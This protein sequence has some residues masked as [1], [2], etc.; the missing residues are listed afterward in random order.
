ME[1][2]NKE[3]TQILTDYDLNKGY[4]KSDYL[5]IEVPE[6]Q[7]VEEQSHYE[8][9]AEYENG[10]KDLK[11]V[12][13]VKGITYQPAHTEKQEIKV[14]IPYTE[15]ELAEQ[16]IVELKT[17]LQATD[18]Q[19]IKFA[20]GL[21]SSIDYEPIKAQRQAWRNKINELEGK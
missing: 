18:Y 5:E 11:K 9:V 16:K 17:Q 12:I 4:L 20:E 15:K 19:A 6:I 10:G 13:D 2:Y 3:K 8:V 7:A 14:Y 21:I 1:V